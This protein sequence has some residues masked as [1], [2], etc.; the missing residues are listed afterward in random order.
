M[1]SRV[2]H[3]FSININAGKKYEA[4]LK[5]PTPQYLPLDD[6]GFQYVLSLFV[7][8][9]TQELVRRG[10]ILQMESRMISDALPKWNLRC[11]AQI[12]ADQ[13]VPALRKQLAAL[14]VLLQHPLRQ[15]I[16]AELDER[17]NVYLRIDKYVFARCA[18]TWRPLDSK[19]EQWLHLPELA[20]AQEYFETL[21]HNMTEMDHWN[22][23]F[24]YCYAHIGSCSEII[25]I[26]KKA[27]TDT[28]GAEV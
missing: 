8:D 1:K 7:R 18:S 5:V 25:A 22:H 21:E 12:L 13:M 3:L 17:R 27:I 11:G 26:V 16:D 9:C 2:S 20:T 19:Q 14:E 24:R 10:T 4:E 28:Y 6:G 15:Q 23:K